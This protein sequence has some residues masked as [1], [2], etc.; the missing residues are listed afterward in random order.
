[1][2]LASMAAMVTG[3]TAF[4]VGNTIKHLTL[5]GNMVAT[6]AATLNFFPESSIE[7]V[8]F[9]NP[10]PGG[11]ALDVGGNSGNV[12]ELQGVGVTVTVDTNLYTATAQYPAKLLDIHQADSVW[13]GLY[14]VG[15]VSDKQIHINT[16]ANNTMMYAPHFWGNTTTGTTGIKSEA[17][18][19]WLADPM[20]DAGSGTITCIQ[21]S[22]AEQTVRGGRVNTPGASTTGILIDTAKDAISISGFVCRHFGTPANCIVP[23]YPLGN[24][25]MV[26]SNPNSTF[27]PGF[28]QGLNQNPTG[29]ASTTGVMMGLGLAFTPK[30]SGFAYMLA[31]GAVANSVS[32]DGAN[33]GVRY[34]TGTAPTNG[35][36]C[37][38]STAGTGQ[39][40]TA[41]AN[42]QKMALNT[43]GFVSAM[44][45]GTAYWVDLC[46]LAV[47]GGTATVTN[48]DLSA[49]EMLAY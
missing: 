5:D 4:R 14:A 25:I 37:T 23:T 6:T 47:T 18:Q 9:A 33:V 46:V 32:G 43:G 2:A 36:A 8:K 19:T 17:L 48:L 44:T 34:G 29:T 28:A 38:G 22:A 12:E 31:K 39:I 10:A 49:R 24:N 42:G 40:V 15:G 41:A 13:Y 3:P 21:L 16:N 35:A 26:G 20:C 30:T 27:I 1:M 45:L 11:T 7:H